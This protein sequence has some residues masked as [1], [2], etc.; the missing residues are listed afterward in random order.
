MIYGR[1]VALS[2]EVTE[3]LLANSRCFLLTRRASGAPTGHPMTLRVGA[4]GDLLFSTYRTSA[5]VRNLVRDPRVACLVTTPADA[6]EQ[7]SVLVT[8]TAEVIDGD[9]G[10]AAWEGSAGGPAV[11]GVGDGVATTVAAR[12]RDGKR[13]VVRVRPTATRGP[14]GTA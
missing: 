10:I 13:V 12:M 11:G 8:G 6:T 9:E 1:F 4:D 2:P 14:E 3:F 5:K 7:R